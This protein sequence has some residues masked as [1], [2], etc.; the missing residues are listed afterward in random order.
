MWY[1]FSYLLQGNYWDKYINSDYYY[2]TNYD[3]NNDISYYT[4]NNHCESNFNNYN[5]TYNTVY[6]DP[7]LNL[8][9]Y[10]INY[11]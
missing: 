5:T 9:D 6:N 11:Y 8:H 2:Y 3:V 7:W 10:E 1:I 4:N